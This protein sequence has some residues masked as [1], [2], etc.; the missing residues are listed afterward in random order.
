MKKFLRRYWFECLIC[1][2][3]FIYMA[4]FS[5]AEVSG[6][7]MYPTYEH[8]DF[9]LLSKYAEIT[10]GDIIAVYSDDLGELL[11]KR[12]IGVNGDHVVIEDGKLY[13][14]DKL[15]EEPYINEQEW[16]SSSIDTLVEYNT[17]FVMGD[18][19]NNSYDSRQLGC[20][21]VSKINGKLVLN[22]TDLIGVTRHRLAQIIGFMWGIIILSLIIKPIKNLCKN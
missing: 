11:C 9:L 7:S 17:V 4:L 21:P 18:N 3:L 22:L 15:I 1:S 14:N 13:V 20:F 12:V 5:T 6:T 2:S 8:G 19:R 10:N 16:Y